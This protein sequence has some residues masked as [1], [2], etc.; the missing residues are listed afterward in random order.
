MSS[1]SLCKVNQKKDVLSYVD[2]IQQLISLLVTD[3]PE[4]NTAEF[5]MVEYMFSKIEEIYFKPLKLFIAPLQKIF[6]SYA[7]HFISMARILPLAGTRPLPQKKERENSI[8]F[9]Q[10]SRHLIVGSTMEFQVTIMALK[11][12]YVW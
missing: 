1:T 3:T 2:G 6:H 7:F 5:V 10:F 12:A 4:C 8:C 9:W 11:K